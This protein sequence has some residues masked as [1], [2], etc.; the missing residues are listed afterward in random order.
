MTEWPKLELTSLEVHVSV[1]IL[2]DAEY[3]FKI[4]TVS[5]AGTL[6]YSNESDPIVWSDMRF[7]TKDAHDVIS[8]CREML[9]LMLSSNNTISMEI[10]GSL[11]TKEIIS[12]EDYTKVSLASTLDE[13]AANLVEALREGMQFAPER[14]Y[15]S[16]AII[17]LCTLSTLWRF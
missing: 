3:V 6:Q 10:A 2:D 5:D 8:R 1:P 14:F 7:F 12:K 9:I 11:S 4:C 17:N 16:Y 15:K 13:K